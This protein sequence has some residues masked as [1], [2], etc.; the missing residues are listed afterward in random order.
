MLLFFFF[1]F[2]S[3][4]LFFPYFLS[5]SLI[6]SLTYPIS[7]FLELFVVLERSQQTAFLVFLISSPAQ[8]ASKEKSVPKRVK[9]EGEGSCSPPSPLAGCSL[10]KALRYAYLRKS[11]RCLF[12]SI[13]LSLLDFSR[14]SHAILS[15]FPVSHN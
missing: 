14:N 4:F 13:Y 15:S 5:P 9:F 6:P 2:F 12:I 8:Q 7:L 11:R 1:L 10:V 3:S